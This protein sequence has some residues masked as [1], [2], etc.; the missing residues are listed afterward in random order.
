MKADFY[1]LRV[2]G[3]FCIFIGGST[4]GASEREAVIFCCS[5]SAAAGGDSPE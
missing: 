2:R 4:S 5:L 3:S 1:A